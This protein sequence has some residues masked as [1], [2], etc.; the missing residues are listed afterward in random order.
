MARSSP[1][2][3]AD[4]A[5]GSAFGRLLADLQVDGN[6]ADALARRTAAFVLALDTESRRRLLHLG[7]HP[8]N[9]RPVVVDAVDVLRPEAALAVLGAAAAAQGRVFSPALRE[10]LGKLASQASSSRPPLQPVAQAAL[11]EQFRLN[12]RRLWPVDSGPMGFGQEHHYGSAAGDDAKYSTAA[13]PDRLVQMSLE[14]DVVATQ[15]WGQV[16]YLLQQG[17]FREVVDMLKAVPPDSRA[18]RAIGEH[19]VTPERLKELL[20]EEPVDWAAVDRFVAFMGGPG[21]EALLDE[22]LE[23][24]NR[25]TRRAIFDRLRKRGAEVRPYIPVRLQDT[26]WYV[27]RN[28]VA[29]LAE[30]EYWPP[31]VSLERFLNHEDARVRREALRML[32]RLPG[33]REQALLAALNESDPGALQALAGAD[34]DAVSESIVPQVVRRLSGPDVPSEVKAHAIRLLRRSRSALVLNAL[35]EV[36]HGGK[37]LFGKMKLPRKSPELLEALKVL[38][39]SWARER[40]AAVVLERARASKDPEIVAAATPSEEQ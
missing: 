2:P 26:R 40:R 19:I 28:L 5:V 23:S 36:T 39:T 15:V 29:L 35:L 13:E 33:K 24:E 25:S 32:M 11:R 27:L 20:K 3:E 22:L 38:A 1:S 4:A 8:S 14:L 21:I 30:L 37:T 7:G 31:T 16:T 9:R 10:V 18:A 12:I 6:A 17:R 34:V